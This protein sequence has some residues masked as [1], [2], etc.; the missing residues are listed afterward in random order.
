M[1]KIFLSIF[2]YP[3]NILNTLNGYENIDRNIFFTVKEERRTRGHGV[4]LAKKQCRLDIR[5]YKPSSGNYAYFF[6]LEILSFGTHL[7]TNVLI[8][9]FLLSSFDYNKYVNGKSPVTL[10]LVTPKHIRNLKLSKQEI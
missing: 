7:V 10:C 8:I 1:K 9:N 5:K 4:T 6:F 3:F 2:S